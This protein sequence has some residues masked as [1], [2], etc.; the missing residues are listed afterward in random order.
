MKYI[1]QIEIERPINEV[2]S[3]FDNPENYR[4]WMEGLLSL[5]L[6]E[7]ATG[8]VGAKS[9]FKFKMGKREMEMTEAVLVRDLPQEYV[10]QYNAKGVSNSVKS[11]FSAIDGQKTLY[12]TENEFEFSGF[13]K[14]IAFLMPGSFKKQSQKYLTDFKNFVE[15]STSNLG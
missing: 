5:E 11:R 9:L 14:V 2:V 8:Q 12:I 13:M 15:N 3:L 1:A 4:F 10:V 7:G 6:M